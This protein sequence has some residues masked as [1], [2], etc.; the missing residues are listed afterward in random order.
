MDAEGKAIYER[1]EANGTASDTDDVHDA[2]EPASSGRK[3]QATEMVELAEEH[4][5]VFFHGPDQDPYVQ[6][7]VDTHKEVW[8]V[9]SKGYRQLL[10][11]R[12]YRDR[13]KAPGSQA[14]QDALGTLEGKAVF[15]GERREVHVRLA[16]FDGAIYLDLA[17][18]QW[19]AIQIDADGWRVVPAPGVFR[20]PSGLLPIPTPVS[21]GDINELRDFLNVTD[22]GWPMI[23]GALVSYL[24]PSGPF[25]VL[26]LIALQGSGKS[27]TVK[28][29]RL[30]IDPSVAGLRSEPREQRDLMIAATNGW[31]A[32]F[33]NISRI[34]DWLSDAVCRLATGG[35]FATRELHTDRDEILFEAR[36]PVIMN[37]IEEFVTRGDLLD[38]TVLQA[39]PPIAEDKRR[40]EAEFWTAFEEARPRLLGALLDA[41][42]GAMR[43]IDDTHLPT[44][45]R[46]ADF[47]LWATAAEPELG[48]KEGAFMK[49]YAQNRAAANDIALEASPISVE[50]R[51]FV[52]TKNEWEGTATDLLAALDEQASEDVRRRKDWP[53]SARA[54]G[55][56]LR[57]ITPNLKGE[58]IEVVFGRPGGKARV[59]SLSKVAEPH[60]EQGRKLASLTSLASEQSLS[61]DANDAHDGHDDEYP[62]YSNVELGSFGGVMERLGV[63]A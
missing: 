2:Q 5:D 6:V 25:P 7:D 59:I 57:R 11:S 19:E 56:A 13:G 24:R 33:D 48:L 40:S 22:E 8:P 4:G 21:G 3:S 12:Y 16:E 60:L 17:N 45:P 43:R 32:A 18:E 14:I 55:G 26:V 37:G 10:R 50:V 9:K 30:L 41:V 38:R 53:K 44:L 51:R 34:P 23:A 31:L 28:V 54:L 15:E 58:G 27:T 49:A 20:R 35:G 52:E 47:A 63:E 62:S 36:R 42:S 46:M 29:I 39:L 61:H 1:M